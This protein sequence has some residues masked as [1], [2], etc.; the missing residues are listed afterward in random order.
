[1][2]SAPVRKAGSKTARPVASSG[3]RSSA[4]PSAPSPD[5]AT[6][7]AQRVVAGE[8][9]AGR[10]VRLACERHL[11]DLEQGHRRG[12]RFDVRDADLAIDFFLY[13]NHSKGEWAGTPVVLEL[14]ECFIVGSLFGWKRADGTRRFREALVEIAKKNGKSLLGAGVGLMLAFFDGELGAEVYAAATK[15]DQAKIPWGEARRMVLKS[16]RLKSVITVL[17]SNLSMASTASKFEPLGADAD[18]MDGP[19][20]HGAI[21]DELHA[22]K[23]RAMVDVLEGGVASRRQ[24]LFFYIT[25]AGS[26]RTSICWEKHTYAA[27]VL[28]GVL[29]DDA[30]FAFIATLDACDACHGQGKMAPSSECGDCDDWRDP[31]V[32]VKANPNLGVSVKLDFIAAK[33]EKA[34]NVPGQVN[35]VLRL[36]MNV[37]TETTSRWLSMEAWDACAGVRDLTDF[38]AVRAAIKGIAAT[39]QG[40]QCFA[41]LDLSSRSDITALLLWFPP[42]EA[43]LVDVLSFFWLPSAAVELGTKRGVPYDVWVREGFMNETEGDI[44]D[45]DEISEFIRLELAPNVEIVEVGYDPWGATQ[46]ALQ[47]QKEGATVTPVAQSYQ[48]MNEPAKEIES[49]VTSRR[50]RHGGHPVLRWMMSNVVIERDSQDRMRLSKLKSPEKIDGASAMVTAA[51]R[52]ISYEDEEGGISLFVP[53]DDV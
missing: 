10:Y 24:P 8:I 28:E 38:D 26:D 3:R 12:L 44:I 47:L 14:W 34:K 5:R 36:H 4:S 35:S 37:W 39:R 20:I 51:S 1:M 53:G 18:T 48:H 17:T 29:Q 23:T 22:H 52:A 45:Y 49:R 16:P 9:V 50:L 6:L 21:V 30:H 11:R 25:T 43:G 40:T 27:R 13:L 41:G 32:W 46:L 33:V 42:D 15:R 7:Y 19:N 2:V 31:S